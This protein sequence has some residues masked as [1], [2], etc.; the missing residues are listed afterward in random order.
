VNY[1]TTMTV[2]GQ[3]RDLM[4]YWH[5]QTVNGG[6]RL[7]LT[8]QL[9]EFSDR[10][11][12]QPF[13]LNS[14]Y[15]KPVTQSVKVGTE[16]FWQLRAHV[17]GCS[18]EK[19][20]QGIDMEDFDYRRTGYWHIAQTFQCRKGDRHKRGFEN[21]P[22][23]Q[24]TFAPVWQRMDQFK[25]RVR[26]PAMMAPPG[27]S[28]GSGS[29]P[30]P[31]SISALLVQYPDLYG[32]LLLYGIHIL[33]VNGPLETQETILNDDGAYG[34]FDT[35]I[36]DWRAKEKSKTPKKNIQTLCDFLDI[37]VSKGVTLC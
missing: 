21:A 23:L 31:A 2:D 11:H 6:D 19:G 8:L 7:I 5:G 16:P 24:V 32:I 9:C 27:S 10:N 22:P 35:V 17:Y 14:Y 34:D 36:K 15:K 26:A 12:V 18:I 37:F 28:S 30:I 13:S 33:Q 1:V 4:N 29:A 20:I 3:N 25:G